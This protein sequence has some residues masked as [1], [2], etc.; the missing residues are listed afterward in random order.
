MQEFI[1][2]LFY[3][4]IFVYSI[5]MHEV[6]H[7]V[8]ALWLGD[9][10]A[11]YAGRLTAN[12]LNHIDLQL[13]IILPLLTFF[14]T[15]G[16]FAFGAA[17]PVPYNPYNL[18]NQK[19]GPTLVGR[20]SPLSNF[21]VATVATLIAKVLPITVNTKYAIRDGFI[22]A[23]GGDGGSF[24]DRWNIMASMLSGSFANIFFGIC[25][26]IIFWNIF[27]AIFNLIP[28]PPLDGSK[29]I[30][31]IFSIRTGIIMFFE[32]YGF[33]LLLAIIFIDGATFNIIGH[34]L[35]FFLQL[36]FGIAI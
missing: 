25:I 17:K 19:W 27:I 29:L 14:M 30:F 26:M 11:K 32:Q 33:M 36:F 23:V 3:V 21:L 1:L 24:F 28:I 6:A 15:M 13:T 2:I 10:T 22:F 9:K 18:R 16:R 4:T 7:G 20:A 5:I 8:M 35:G 31:S 34:L 12:P